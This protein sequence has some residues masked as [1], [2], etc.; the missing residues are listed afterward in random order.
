MIEGQ[1]GSCRVIFSFY[2][3][4]GGGQ[5][6]DLILALRSHNLKNHYFSSE[7]QVPS[8]SSWYLEKFNLAFS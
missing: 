8:G 4:S 1:T 5:G 7:L 2:L 3:R 6:R